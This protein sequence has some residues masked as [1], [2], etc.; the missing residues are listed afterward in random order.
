MTRVLFELRAGE[1]QGRISVP[2]HHVECVHDEDRAPQPCAGFN[3]FEWALTEACDQLPWRIVAPENDAEGDMEKMV[4]L[5]LH[6]NGDVNQTEYFE[7][8]DLRG[9]E[10]LKEFV[11]R[12]EIV[13]E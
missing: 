9:P 6:K 5:T 10:W 13:E 7:D 1:Y 11:V 4:Y 12:A 2:V 8:A 3:A